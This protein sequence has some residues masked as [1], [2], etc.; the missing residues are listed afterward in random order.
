MH[1]AFSRSTHSSTHA[2]ARSHAAIPMPAD[3]VSMP[4]PCVHLVCVRVMR[5]CMRA[6][7]HAAYARRIHANRIRHQPTPPPPSA[8]WRGA[9]GFKRSLPFCP[10]EHFKVY[11]HG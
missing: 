5:A 3:Q 11:S 10:D 6:P 2:F 8:A 9:F 1:K 7:C 4:A